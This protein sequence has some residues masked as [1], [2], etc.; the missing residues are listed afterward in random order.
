MP[1]TEND[2]S[3]VV[4]EV[5]VRIHTALATPANATKAI[6]HGIEVPDNFS[7]GLFV[8]NHGS[9]DEKH[10]DNSW[11]LQASYAKG[12]VGNAGT[13]SYQYVEDFTNGMIGSYAYNYIT[14]TSKKDPTGREVFADLYAYAPYYAPTG[15][16]AYE[17]L[18]PTAIPFTIA[19]DVSEQADLMYATE[20]ADQS[21]NKGLSALNEDVETLE[22]NFTFTHALALLA[23]EFKIKNFE[24]YSNTYTLQ[25]IQVKKTESATTA[26]LYGSGTFNA[27]DGT[28]NSDCVDKDNLTIRQNQVIVHQNNNADLTA[29]VALVPTQIEDDELEIHFIFNKGISPQ[30]EVKPF[31]LKKEYLKHEDGIN[32]GIK[33]GYKYT[34]RFTLDNYLFLDGFT[35]GTWE[36]GEPLEDIAI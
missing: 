10:K 23:F 4:R 15:N 1:A 14:I 29:Y 16:A 26:K 35:V 25:S 34:L 32:Y 17:N 2:K 9:T 20:N 33:G 12:Q 19:D 5:P 8:C 24:T 22:A 13:W 36:D 21:K 6:V 11:N 7:Y 28:F 27:I 3:E 18:N 30:I 31:V